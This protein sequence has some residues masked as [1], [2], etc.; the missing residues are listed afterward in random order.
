MLNSFGNDF[1]INLIP[2]LRVDDQVPVNVYLLMFSNRVYGQ[3]DALTII[4]RQHFLLS[5]D[6]MKESRWANKRLPAWTIVLSRATR[7]APLALP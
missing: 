1:R 2:N 5:V 6:E 3:Y 7:T 4:F